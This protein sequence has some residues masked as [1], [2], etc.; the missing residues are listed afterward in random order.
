MNE[1]ANE[2]EFLATFVTEVIAGCFQTQTNNTDLIRFPPRPA[3]SWLKTKGWLKERLVRTAAAR[4]FVYANGNQPAEIAQKLTR[5]LSANSAFSDFYRRLGDEPSRRQAVKLLAFSVLGP[6]RIKLPQNTPEFWRAV[7]RVDGDLLRQKNTIPL[8]VN[9]WNLD[10]YDLSPLALPITLHAH[11]LN[12]LDTFLLEQ[13][14]YD[15]GGVRIAVQPGDTVI[16][17]GGCWGDSALYFAHQAGPNGHVFCFEFTPANLEIFAKNLALTPALEPRITVIP[18]AVWDRSG[19]PLVYEDRGPGTALSRS[20]LP[21][22]GP[23]AQTIT[24]DDFVNENSLNRVDLLKMDIEGA[25]PQA[26]RGAEQT[27]RKFRPKLAIAVYHKWDDF[28][29]IPKYLH[30]LNLGYEFY[31]DHFT[32]HQE[33]TVLFAR[34][35]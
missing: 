6:D 35:V 14:R 7:A 13:Y 25:E 24:V 33:E 10:L 11:R 8:A 27:L 31:L 26:L 1:T 5:I 28:I 15:K 19:E 34:P 20:A 32:I 21:G 23:V 12:I 29:T 22:S 18:K 17:A 3:G 4:G 2:N 9:D 16:D 30:E